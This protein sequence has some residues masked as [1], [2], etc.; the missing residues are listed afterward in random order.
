VAFSRDGRTLA[1]GDSDGRTLLW[2]VGDL[3]RPIRQLGPSLTAHIRGA[4][5]TVDFSPTADV[6]AAGT[7]D[8]VAMIW[9]V[10]DPA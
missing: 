5:T 8:N 2:D 7:G 1:T 4:I 3:T 10:S 6:L 9:D